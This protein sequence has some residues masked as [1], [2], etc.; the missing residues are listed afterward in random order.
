MPQL[1]DY[2]SNNKKILEGNKDMG[3]SGYWTIDN[4]RWLE[5]VRY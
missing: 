5:K 3:M 1:A 2:F 4:S